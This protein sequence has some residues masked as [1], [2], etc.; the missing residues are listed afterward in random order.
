[1]SK[2]ILRVVPGTLSTAG[3]RREG[4]KEGGPKRVENDLFIKQGEIRKND[5]LR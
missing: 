5:F 2:L 3:R 1:M 4:E